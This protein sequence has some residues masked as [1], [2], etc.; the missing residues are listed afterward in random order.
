VLEAGL[1]W[2]DAVLLRLKSGLCCVQTVEMFK[3]QLDAKQKEILAFQQE[4]KIRFKVGGPSRAYATL[5]CC[6]SSA[7]HELAGSS[8]RCHHHIYRH[9]ICILYKA[10][11]YL[12]RVVMAP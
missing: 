2:T 8:L 5:L 1:F 9:S 12:M 3:K 4:Y 11:G 6:S 7:L 10:S